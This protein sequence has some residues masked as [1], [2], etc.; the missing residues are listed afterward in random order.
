MA[1]E[2]E[3]RFNTAVKESTQLSKRPNNDTLLEIYALY[4]QA[5]EGD[6]TGERPGFMD[7]KGGA[8]HDAW[9]EKKGTGK[10]DAMQAYVDL[11]ERL[12]AKDKA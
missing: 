9:T 3:T 11:V 12:K 4:K 7:F 6:V 2:L 10:E 8:K 1:S 5:T